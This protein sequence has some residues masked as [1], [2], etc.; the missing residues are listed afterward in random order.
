MGGKEAE[1]GIPGKLL[2]DREEDGWERDFE[3]VLKEG[4][5]RSC[6]IDEALTLD[7]GE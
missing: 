2:C 3:I 6:G 7:G 1:S 5:A 4:I